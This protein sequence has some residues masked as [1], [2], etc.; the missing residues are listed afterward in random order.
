[1][2]RGYWDSG[3]CGGG[4]IYCAGEDSGCTTCAEAESDAAAA[5]ELGQGAIEALD[6]GDFETAL[7]LVTQAAA[8]E[9]R[10]G[11]DPTWHPVVDALAAATGD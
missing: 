7:Q 3:G 2:Y 10:W 8:L 4:P 5:G 6:A 11:D 9:L 1:M